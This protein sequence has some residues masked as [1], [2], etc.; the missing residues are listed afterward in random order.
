MACV[1]FSLLATSC[2]VS[3]LVTWWTDRAHGPVSEDAESYLAAFPPCND[4]SF[5]RDGTV[6]ISVYA[7]PAALA[8]ADDVVSYPPSAERVSNAED[9]AM[10]AA[11]VNLICKLRINLSSRTH[12]CLKLARVS[13]S[14]LIM[15]FCCR[16]C[17]FGWKK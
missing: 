12:F 1:L 9:A 7:S 17:S 2:T 5:A 10:A 11:Q 16:S 3:Q 4:I 14:P 8:A 15:S 13:S 6:T